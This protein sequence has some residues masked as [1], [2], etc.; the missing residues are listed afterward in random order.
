[1][2]F[3]NVSV[4]RDLRSCEEIVATRKCLSASESIRLYLEDVTLMDL[5]QI[6]FH[7]TMSHNYE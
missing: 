3:V 5:R 1:M 7:Y 2:T 6:A 4:E